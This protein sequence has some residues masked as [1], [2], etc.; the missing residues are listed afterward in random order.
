MQEVHEL[1][2]TR[3]QHERKLGRLVRAR[4]AR[5]ERVAPVLDKLDGVRLVVVHA[6]QDHFGGLEHDVVLALALHHHVLI[7]RGPLNL[8]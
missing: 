3:K 5:V 6:S 4:I 1:A 7:W 2:L 8:W